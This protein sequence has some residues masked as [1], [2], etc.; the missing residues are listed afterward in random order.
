MDLKLSIFTN[1]GTVPLEIAK[2]HGFFADEGLTVEIEGT[3]SSIIQMTGVID[4]RYD[5]AASAIDNVIAYNSGRGAAH[6]K[7]ASNLKVFLGSASYRLPFV[8]GAHIKTF[9]DLQGSTIAVDALNTGF[10]FLLRE[11]L[12]INGLSQ[13]RYQFTSVGA[14]KE[15]W[16]AVQNGDATGALLNG[17][18][19]AIAHQAGCHTLVSSPDPWDT[20]E[21]NVFCAGPDFLASEYADA[22]AK[23]VLRGVNFAKNPENINA[24]ALALAQH[25]GGLD[26]ATA[27][28]VARSL[29][30]PKSIIMDGLPVSRS[31]IE[32]VLR[33]REKYTGKRLGLTPDSLCDPRVLFVP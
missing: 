33:L 7:V 8:V 32:T 17:H 23:A 6:T 22:F 20:Y 12:E 31:G 18:F 30:G 15:R 10:A 1:A 5:I 14:P 2:R 11:M 21:G 19:E 27:L 24:V 16:E 26:Q 3:T 4:G 28:K 29:Q 25:L 13:D 9:S